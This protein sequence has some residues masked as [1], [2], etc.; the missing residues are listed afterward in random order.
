M[1]KSPEESEMSQQVDFSTDILCD[2]LSGC[3]SINV[4][5]ENNKKINNLNDK[6]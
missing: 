4:G 6:V 2:T 1:E 5:Y 3:D